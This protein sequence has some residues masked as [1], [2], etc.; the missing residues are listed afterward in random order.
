MTM[1][2]VVYRQALTAVAALAMIMGALLA[3]MAGDGA[4]VDG[5]SAVALQGPASDID[6]P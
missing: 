2:A 1:S 4:A 3:S 6:W 5:G